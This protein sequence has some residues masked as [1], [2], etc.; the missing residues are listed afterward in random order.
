MTWTS[1]HCYELLSHGDLTT[2]SNGWKSRSYINTKV[3][4]IHVDIP[5]FHEVNIL[6]KLKTCKKSSTWCKQWKNLWKHKVIFWVSNVVTLFP[7]LLCF[8]TKRLIGPKVLLVLDQRWWCLLSCQPFWAGCS[9]LRE[10]LI[11]VLIVKCFLISSLGASFILGFQ[12]Q[13]PSSSIHKPSLCT[14]YTLLMTRHCQPHLC[15]GQCQCA[16]KMKM[17]MKRLPYENEHAKQWIQRD[18]IDVLVC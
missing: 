13:E 9:F 18:C 17:W 12:V 14:H 8:L 10:P 4:I 7:F 6:K 3:T 5:S 16:K 2:H 15:W 1:I 11:L